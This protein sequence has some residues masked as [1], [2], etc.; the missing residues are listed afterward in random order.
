MRVEEMFD[1]ISQQLAQMVVHVQEV[2]QSNIRLGERLEALERRF[3]SFEHRFEALEARLDSLEHRFETLEHRF[4]ALEARLDSL[5]HR[6]DS[7]EHRFEALR[8]D[9]EKK[10][11]F[12]AGK[13]DYHFGVLRDELAQFRA[14]IHDELYSQRYRQ[15]EVERRLDELEA[16]V[17]RLEERLR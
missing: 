11:D 1:S 10:I 2:R 8:E 13:I 3:D 5:E 9:V 17:A 6:F 12:L 14:R 7:L 16:R 4:E 15:A